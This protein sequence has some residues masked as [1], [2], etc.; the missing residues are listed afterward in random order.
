MSPRVRYCLQVAGV[1]AVYFIAARLGLRLEAVAGFAAAVWAPSGI[2]LAALLLVGRRLWPAV[3]IGAFLVNLIA[4]ASALVALGIATGNTLAAVGGASALGCIPGFDTSLRRVRDVLALLV[5]AAVASTAVSATIG[6]S[7]LYLGGVIDSGS[8]GRTWL[9]WWLGDMVGDLLVAPLILVWASRRLS[10]REITGARVAEAV[11]LAVSLAAVGLFVSRRPDVFGEAYAFFVPLIWAALRFGQRGIVVS[12]VF[13]AAI[14]ITETAL[15]RGPFAGPPTAES[16]FA[17]QSYLAVTAPALLLLGAA[18]S[19]IRDDERRRAAIMNVALDCLITIDHRG[20][21]VD[22]NPAAEKTFG[23]RR[24]DVLG[25]EMAELIIPERLRDGHRQ[26]LQQYLATGETRILGKR[27]D[28]PAIRADG[29][30]LIAEVAIEAIDTA[31]PPLF[32]GYLRDVTEARL[33][34]TRRELITEAISIFASSLSYEQTMAAVCRLTVPRLADWAAVDILGADGRLQRLAG[35][36]EDPAKSELVADLLRRYPI[37]PAGPEMLAR[38][39]RTGRAE[40]VADLTDSMHE[41]P[42]AASGY[43]DALRNLGVRSCIAVPIRSDRVL[44]AISFGVIQPYRRS[45][46]GDLALAK[47]IAGNAAIAIE[48]SRLYVAQQEARKQAEQAVQARDE[49]ISVA[50][51]ELRNPVSVLHLGMESLRL[52]RA[53]SN[54]DGR[55]DETIE[56]ITRQVN[57]LTLLVDNLLDTSRIAA[58]RLSLELE[59]VDLAAVVRDS[60]IRLDPERQRAQGA[61]ELRA[62]APVTG[63]WDRIRLDQI[64]TNLVSN[65]LKYGAGQPIEISVQADAD[66]ARL[67]VRDHGI[68]IAS[69]D[70]SRIFHQFERVAGTAQIRGFGLGLWIVKQIVDA[71]G[72]TIGVESAVGVGSTFTVELPRRRAAS[73]VEVVLPGTEPTQAKPYAGDA[74][75]S[76]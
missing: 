56:R 71:L 72:G 11:V 20:H 64:A 52:Q 60:V 34:E 15:G 10:L 13:V 53:A 26:G 42:A 5:L 76:R 6:V 1:A 30:E 66:T 14:S 28:V 43:S 50:S 32:I 73:T 16:L 75:S 48:N 29:S 49:L 31:G 22:F 18:I 58:G 12:L 47:R 33:D 17:L 19:S 61:I 63:V 59:E 21:I 51:H 55:I 37:D 2:A 70:Q 67:I 9:T 69:E 46:E 40:L 65:A 45:S 23:H 25:K 39:V 36:H 8:F 62:D 44:G 7:S 41:G 68:G 38:V 24:Q 57:R 3:A 35:V 4:G 27:F 54:G 74:E